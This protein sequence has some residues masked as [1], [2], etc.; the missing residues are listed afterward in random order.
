M[1]AGAAEV[2]CQGAGPNPGEHAVL[3]RQAADL[4]AGGGGKTHRPQA[5]DARELVHVA[6][7]CVEHQRDAQAVLPVALLHDEYPLR[8]RQHPRPLLA[9][10]AAPV[11]VGGAVAQ[12]QG[13][14]AHD[15]ADPAADLGHRP[16][17]A[18]AGALD[19]GPGQLRA[20]ELES[21][22]LP[23]RRRDKPVPA[24]GVL[25]LERQYSARGR[26]KYQGVAQVRARV[27]ERPPAGGGRGLHDSQDELLRV[28]LEALHGPLAR[29]AAVLVGGL[30]PVGEQRTV[31]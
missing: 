5:G 4:A 2:A 11:P 24:S 3:E 31:D 23:T 7:R 13:H 19:V 1:P 28:E 27:L 14:L 25:A 18:A 12:V 8:G 9:A 20:V 16:C 22:D 10:A 17:P 15:R 26:V 21:Y 6:G 29:A 30:A